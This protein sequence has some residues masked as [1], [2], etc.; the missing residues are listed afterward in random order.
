M[1]DIRFGR[2]EDLPL[3]E[4]W[5]HEA[6]E[7]TPW[8]AENIDHLS[9]AIGIPL[10]LTGTEVAVDR[11]SADIVAR[12]LRDDSTVL[13]ENQLEISDRHH[14]GQIMTYIAGVEADTVV[15]IA[16]RFEDAHLAAVRWLN[17][18]TKEGFSFFAVKLRVVR[19][20]ESPYAPIFEIVEKPN[21][22][23][24]TVRAKTDNAQDRSAN[25]KLE[26]WSLLLQRHPDL[27]DI[28]LR[29]TRASNHWIKIIPDE[30]FLGIYAASQSC[31]VYLRGPF[32]Q[33]VEEV[34]SL[35]EPYKT[36]IEESL[37]AT[38]FDGG[39][40]HAVRSTPFDPKRPEQWPE[41]ADKLHELIQP[42]LAFARKLPSKANQ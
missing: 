38:F 39:G 24:R 20:G 11:F 32:N 18:T 8:L 22:W 21:D 10:E 40:W 29:P 31:G 34:A 12:N 36:E 4:A 14:L 33:N 23:E 16:P 25:V 35:L 42:H 13:I 7:F 3:R 2:L 9:E 30:L 28:G 6:H 5:K 37:D 1:T 19:I 15:W 41:T 17:E 27:A 26:F